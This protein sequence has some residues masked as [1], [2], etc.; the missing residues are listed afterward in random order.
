MDEEQVDPVEAETLQRLVQRAA[1]SVGPMEAVVELGRDIE[2]AAG[3]TRRGD[4]GPHARLVAVHLGGVEVAI[5]DLEG[6]GDGR[7]GLRRGNL[8]DAE[9]ELGDGRLV[10]QRD[11]GD[12]HVSPD[13]HESTTIPAGSAGEEA[14]LNPE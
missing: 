1:R 3:Q 6:R 9:A 5:A 8:E 7:L 14:L 10:A 11:R 13:N 4:R 12:G 2:V